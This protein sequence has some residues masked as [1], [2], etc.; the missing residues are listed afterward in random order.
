[1]MMKFP[2]GIADFYCLIT[3][4]YFYVD[5]T[6]KIPVLEEIG[7]HLLFLRPRRCG[8]S[9]LLSTLEN[10]YD[11]LKADR[12]EQLFGHTAVGKNPTSWHNRFMVLSLD[13]SVVDPTGGIEDIRYRFTQ[14]C[15]IK[16]QSV[17]R[18]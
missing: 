4:G 18:R 15:N 7:K 2:Y 17:A 16:L 13:F 10:Y 14:H 8:K 12:F 3:E 5:R 1:M 9:L 11:V 6:A